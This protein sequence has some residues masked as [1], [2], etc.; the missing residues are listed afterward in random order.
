M[1][2]RYKNLT[3]QHHSYNYLSFYPNLKYMK[4]IRTL[5]NHF[6]IILPSNSFYF[7]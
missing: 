2:F 1:T 5:K 3:A 6:N 7:Y 4:Q